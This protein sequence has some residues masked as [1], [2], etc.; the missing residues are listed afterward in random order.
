MS[1]VG[2]A[3]CKC[4]CVQRMQFHTNRKTA[5]S[6][7]S[8]ALDRTET[9]TSGREAKLWEKRQDGGAKHEGIVAKSEREEQPS[10]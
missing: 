2:D 4:E 3:G 5:L 9:D 1:H 10:T 7:A 8:D 6:K